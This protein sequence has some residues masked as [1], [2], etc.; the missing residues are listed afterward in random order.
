[1]QV[2]DLVETFDGGL[3]IVVSAPYRE[4]TL[5]ELEDSQWMID[6]MY[7]DGVYATFYDAVELVNESR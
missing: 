5:G 7:K 2:G 6:V 1:V 3:G 4:N